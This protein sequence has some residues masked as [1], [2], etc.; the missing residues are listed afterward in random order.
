MQ[1]R[2]LM[3]SPLLIVRIRSFRYY[4]PSRDSICALAHQHLGE[5]DAN[6]VAATARKSKILAHM[7][8]IA[9]IRNTISFNLNF[10]QG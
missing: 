3:Y 5:S 4:T 8:D 10:P 9:Q 2:G 1:V 6:E 7:L